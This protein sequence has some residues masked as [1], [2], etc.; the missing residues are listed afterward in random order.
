[1]THDEKRHYLLKTLLQERGDPLPIPADGESQRRLLR[2]LLNVRR[3]APVSDAFLQVQDEYLAERLAQRGVTDSA[4]LVPTAEGF[5]LW[6]GDITALR[7]D[8]IVNAANSGMLGCF[9]PCHGC[10][11]NAI[12][13]YAGIELRLFMAQLMAGQG[14]EPVGRARISPAFNL[15]SQYVLHTVGPMVSGRLTPH[16]ES[17]LASCYRTCLA[18][19][20]ENGLQSLAFCCISTGEFLFPPLRAAEIALG[21]VRDYRAQTQSKMKVIFN[22]FQES[23]EQIYRR[24]LQ[25]H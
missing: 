8:A 9:V 3:P 19:A 23:D 4:N 24:L 15:P 6:R 11:D 13:T 5:C 14:E 21:T 1:M 12:H 18:L 22:V 17:Q 2:A 20:D 16:H 7:A 25:R 10:I